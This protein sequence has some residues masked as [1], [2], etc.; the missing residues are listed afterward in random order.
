MQ[1]GFHTP[2]EIKSEWKRKALHKIYRIAKEGQN[3]HN[4][5]LPSR[6]LPV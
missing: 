3:N 6:S 5:T 2:E 1:P 4:F